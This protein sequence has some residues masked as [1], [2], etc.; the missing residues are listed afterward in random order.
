MNVKAYGTCINYSALRVNVEYLKY[1]TLSVELIAWLNF[2]QTARRRWQ[3]LIYSKIPRLLG[4]Q[5]VHHRAQ[6]SPY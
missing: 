6:M 4:D 1:I 3:S 5:N 2:N